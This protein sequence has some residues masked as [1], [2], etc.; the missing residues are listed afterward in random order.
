VQCS[1]AHVAQATANDPYSTEPA[2]L[3]VQLRLTAMQAF[4]N[5]KPFS[6]CRVWYAWGSARPGQ[7]EDLQCCA[8]TSNTLQW[9]KTA[10]AAWQVNYG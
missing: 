2:R 1:E 8:T 5:C 3:E 9:P 6:R 4:S 7:P 10:S